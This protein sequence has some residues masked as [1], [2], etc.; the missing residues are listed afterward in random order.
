[1][2]RREGYFFVWRGARARVVDFARSHGFS[3]TR[4]NE[5]PNTNQS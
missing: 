4:Q 2:K 1:V 3:Q 5:S